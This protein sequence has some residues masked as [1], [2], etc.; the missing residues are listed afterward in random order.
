MALPDLDREIIVVDDGSRDQTPE[1]LKTMGAIRFFRHEKNQ[2]KGAAVKT[3]IAQAT[4]DILL[5][6]DADLEYTPQDYPALLKPILS[7]QTEFVMGSRFL[8]QRPRFFTKE[9]DPFFSHYI[10]NRLI[11]VL[12][13]FLYGQKNTDYEGC[14]KV[15]TRSL[16]Q[17]FSIKANGFAFE[18]ELTCKALRRGYRIVEVPIRYKPRLYSEGKKITW[19]DGLSILWNIVK[20]RFL[21]F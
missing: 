18:N 16:I 5:V 19:Q 7:G 17:S 21:P 15:F 3:G 20:W 4:G 8:F 13:N 2:G 9:G 10:G 1:I 12:A 14:Y 6:Q 11:I